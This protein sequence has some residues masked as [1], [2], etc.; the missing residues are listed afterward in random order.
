MNI[1]I[2]GGSFDPFHT[3]HESIVNSCLKKLDIDKLFIVPTFLNPFKHSS[4][5]D[6]NI[7]LELIKEIYKDNKNIEII[8]YEVKQNKKI[9]SY[10]TVV[11]LKNNYNIEKI[12]FIIG[13]DNLKDIHLWYNFKNLKELVQ[14]VVISR[15]GIHLNNEYIN[16]IYIDLQENISSSKL[17]KNMELK[18]IPIKIQKKVKKLWKIE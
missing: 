3:G 6:A 11:Y 16:P 4:F 7:R 15:D 17:R 1:A 12:F 5:L 8:D 2:F 10:E 18:Y 13:A 14:F 9:P